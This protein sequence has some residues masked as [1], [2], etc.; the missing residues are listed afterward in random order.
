[1]QESISRR[2]FL[3]GTAIGAGALAVGAG[4]ASLLTAAGK[5]YAAKKPP[6]EPEPIGYLP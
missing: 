5:A 1:M 3:K 4:G 6:P 2:N